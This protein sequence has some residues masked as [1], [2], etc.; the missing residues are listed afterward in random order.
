MVTATF[1][2]NNK[3]LKWVL[4][5]ADDKLGVDWI[6]KIKVWMKGEKTPT[7]H[8]LQVL[9]KKSQIPFGK[10]ML[11]SVTVWP[12]HKNIYFYPYPLKQRKRPQAYHLQRGSKS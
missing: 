5:I 7:I 1:K 2:V 3:I 8:Q 4:Q 9:S 6:D 10:W 12:A 11:V